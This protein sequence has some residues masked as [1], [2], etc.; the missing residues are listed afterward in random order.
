MESHCG[1]NAFMGLG[2]AAMGRPGNG[3]WF[4][5]LSFGYGYA[6]VLSPAGCGHD[7]VAL[8]R[9]VRRRFWEPVLGRPSLEPGRLRGRVGTDTPIGVGAFGK[10][11]LTK[12]GR[13]GAGRGFAAQRALLTLYLLVSLL[14]GLDVASFSHSRG[15]TS[16]ALNRSVGGNLI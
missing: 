6:G 4:Q 10:G 13:Q 5:V 11:L 16:S 2:K 1:D 12:R 9:R 7:G 8:G 14:V 15:L 3:A